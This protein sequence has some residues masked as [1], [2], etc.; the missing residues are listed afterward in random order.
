MSTRRFRRKQYKCEL[1][2]ALGARYLHFFEKMADNVHFC[3]SFVTFVQYNRIKYMLIWQESAF[4][5][6]RDYE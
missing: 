2:Y 6:V 5:C 3:V 4:V 1:F